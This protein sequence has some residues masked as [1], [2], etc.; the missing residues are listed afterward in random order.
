MQ[1]DRKRDDRIRA[2]DI[3]TSKWLGDRLRGVFS[4]L[5]YKETGKPQ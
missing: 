2:K 5:I 1:S 4:H 3:V